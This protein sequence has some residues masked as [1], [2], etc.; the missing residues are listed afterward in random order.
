MRSSG[1]T[2]IAA[3]V[4][5]AVTLVLV[6]AFA[7]LVGNMSGMLERIGQDLQV[8]AYLEPDLRME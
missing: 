4:T 2:C 5:I 8:T 3:V 1:V 6:G 7:L